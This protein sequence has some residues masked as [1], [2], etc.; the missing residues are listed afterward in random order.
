MC[1]WEIRYKKPGSNC[2]RAVISCFFQKQVRKVHFGLRIFPNSFFAITSHILILVCYDPNSLIAEHSGRAVWGMKCLR[3]D[4]WFES[5]SRHGCLS[6]FIMCLRLGS[7]LYLGSSPV[8]G[9]LQTK[10]KKLQWN[11][12][13]H[14]CP[15]LQV[16]A[17]GI[18][19]G[20]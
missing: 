9:V 13:F 6:A 4:H 1:C 12:I 14:G 17:T 16:G 2:M 19:I 15:M 5:H 20:R 11:E 8:W 18:K 3:W 7:S 10:I